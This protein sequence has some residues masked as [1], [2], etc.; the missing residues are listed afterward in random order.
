RI[1]P[2]YDGPV[3]HSVDASRAV[4][5]ASALVS[6]TQRSDLIKTTAEAYESL[7][8][9]RAGRGHSELATLDETRANSF[10]FDP[11]GQP[12]PPRMPGLH[13]FGEWPLRD[14]RA[15]IDWTPFFRAWELA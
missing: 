5:V 7:R 1:D 13:Q 11:N 15:S 4:G 14:L 6:D 3:I 12:T 9:S 8:Q 10:A 2:A